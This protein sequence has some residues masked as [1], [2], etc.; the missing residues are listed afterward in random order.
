MLGREEA[1]KPDKPRTGV[2]CQQSEPQSA[3]NLQAPSKQQLG[4]EEQQAR[5]REARPERASCPD[6]AG[7]LLKELLRE[8]QAQATSRP[9]MP[10]SSRL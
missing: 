10:H 9:D 8:E 1:D 2:A 3:P 6:A 5:W 7:A 4:G